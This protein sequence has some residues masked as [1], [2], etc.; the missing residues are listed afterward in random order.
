MTK[1]QALM[2]RWESMLDDNPPEVVFATTNMYE[3]LDRLFLVLIIR[4]L[5]KQ[6]YCVS[7]ASR[8]LGVSPMTVRKYARIYIP[9][10]RQRRHQICVNNK[11]EYAL[12]RYRRRKQ[13]V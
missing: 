9:D 11:R 5:R 2:Q 12:A 10:Y 4:T 1:E 7:H 6:Q 3:I 13:A 8:V